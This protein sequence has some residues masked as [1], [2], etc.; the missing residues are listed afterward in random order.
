MCRPTVGLGPQRLS[1]P[2]S[3]AKLNNYNFTVIPYPCMNAYIHC[4][5]GVDVWGVVGGGLQYR[6][7][8]FR[9]DFVV[10]QFN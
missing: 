1:V 4:D 5:C 9:L 3:V 2:V 8:H 6:N 7:L 10:M